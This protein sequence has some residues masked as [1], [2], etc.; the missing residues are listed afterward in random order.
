MGGHGALLLHLRNP[1]L[2]SSVSAFAPIC[3]AST[4]QFGKDLYSKMLAKQEEGQE[5]DCQSHLERHVK[6]GTELGQILIDVGS[7]DCYEDD[8]SIAKFQTLLREAK[9]EAR[10]NI[11]RDF[12]HSYYF[13]SSFLGEHL[14]FHGRALGCE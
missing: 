6:A 5:W 1:G 7:A 10:V 2:Y 4:S 13:V 9:A 8:L 14:R 11:R 12:G 3:S